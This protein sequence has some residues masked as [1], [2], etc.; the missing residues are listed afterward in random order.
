MKRESVFDLP[1]KGL[2]VALSELTAAA[3]GSDFSVAKERE[4]F[5]ELFHAVWFLIEAHSHTEEGVTFAELDQR[6]P[7]ATE[8]LRAEHRDLDTVYAD[9]KLAVDTKNYIEATEK[10]TADLNRFTA[11]FQ[12]HMNREEDEVEPLVWAHFSD[13][14]IQEHRRRIMA[15]DG[16]EKLLK[17]FRFVFFALNEN[18][19]AG[20]L[21]RLKVMISADAYQRAE[22]LAV[23]ATRRRCLRL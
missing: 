20:M 11:A 6:M 3:T 19:A 1:H 17:Y 12:A 7:G 13:E 2:R 14:E 8:S 18:Q 15:A 4:I 23:A 9:L 16:P 21:A 22:A 10:F 5:E